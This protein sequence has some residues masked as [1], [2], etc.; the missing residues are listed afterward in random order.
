MFDVKSL[1]HG[2]I[3]EI[4]KGLKTADTHIQKVVL[5]MRISFK[6]GEKVKS[7][8]NDWLENFIK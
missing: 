1:W 8:Y 5:E 6:E 4:R 2:G 3:A 7:I